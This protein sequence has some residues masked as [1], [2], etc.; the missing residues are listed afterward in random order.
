M[1]E[2]RAGAWGVFRVDTASDKHGA[3]EQLDIAGDA[4]GS[5]GGRGGGGVTPSGWSESG[6]AKAD[7][8][9]NVKEKNGQ[10]GVLN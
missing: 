1:G 6:L 2:G 4:G 9:G 3:G 5:G 7:Q 8:L 10:L